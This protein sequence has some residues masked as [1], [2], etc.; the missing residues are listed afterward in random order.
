MK[1]EVMDYK[2]HYFAP[3]FYNGEYRAEE[4]WKSPKP[5]EPYGTAPGSKWPG[6]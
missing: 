5:P 2:V 6:L 1:I 3:S 4:L